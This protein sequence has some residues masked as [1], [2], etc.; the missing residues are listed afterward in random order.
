MRDGDI[1]L[2]MS[3]YTA[4]Q[5]S[6]RRSRLPEDVLDEALRVSV[7]HAGVEATHLCVDCGQQMQYARLLSSHVCHTQRSCSI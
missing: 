5:M 7:A 6:I 2:R 3:T 1:S 4:T